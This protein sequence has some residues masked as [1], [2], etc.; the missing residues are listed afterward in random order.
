MLHL[1]NKWA[2]E[3]TRLDLV[4]SLETGKIIVIKQPD[5]RCGVES[6]TASYI[7]C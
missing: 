1:Q 7:R 6:R 5:Y 4:A 2:S 3:K